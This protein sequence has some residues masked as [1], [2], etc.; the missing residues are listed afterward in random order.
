M[1]KLFIS[2][3]ICLLAIS[4]AKDKKTQTTKAVTDSLPLKKSKE[5]STVKIANIKDPVINP[6]F[7]LELLYGIW[8][9]DNNG[10]HADF[11]LTKKSFYVVDYDGDGSMP[12]MINY[13]TITVKYPDYNNIGIIKKVVKDTLIINWNSGV[14]VTYFTWKG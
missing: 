9:V 11:E 10:P 6:K 8:T 1:I 12:Y 7:D 5:K 4:C 13:D 3:F 2:I 14:D